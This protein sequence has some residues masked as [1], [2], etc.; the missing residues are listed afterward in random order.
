[1][2]LD[3]ETWYREEHPRVAA[4]LI[5]MS[6]D[7]DLA[8]DAT[9]EAFVRALTDWRRV[10]TME[11]AAAWTIKVGI[12]VVRRRKR[13]QGLEQRWLAAAAR[14]APASEDHPL[15][16]DDL[17]A[18]VRDLPERQRQAVV[19]RY[20][21]DLAEADIAAVMGVRRGTVASTLADARRRLAETS[22]RDDAR[23]ELRNG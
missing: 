9:D 16:D 7:V 1:V 22:T 17:W 12:N 14:Q 5:A 18:A 11:S 4:V 19:L 10:G 8:R 23:L 20:V 6:G 21:A 2:S 13:R 15:P 3:F